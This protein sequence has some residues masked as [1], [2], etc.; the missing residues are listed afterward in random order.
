MFVRNQQIE[1]LRKR[2]KLRSV[3]VREPSKKIRT[4]TE[5]G[6]I[7]IL[8]TILFFKLNLQFFISIFYRFWRA[9]ARISWIFNAHTSSKPNYII[10]AISILHSTTVMD[11]SPVP[12][13]RNNYIRLERE[14]KSHKSKTKKQLQILRSQTPKIYVLYRIFTPI[15]TV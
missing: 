2:K 5:P 4:R 12:R 1:N 7:R 14:L 9:N 11:N 10:K 13:Y 8:K 15:S 3:S 6:V